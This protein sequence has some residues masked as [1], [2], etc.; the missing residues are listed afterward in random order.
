MPD[1]LLYPVTETPTAAP[2]A[3]PYHQPLALDVLREAIGRFDSCTTA[4]ETLRELQS[5]SRLLIPQARCGVMLRQRDG[6][7]ELACERAD[8]TEPAAKA[9]ST[10]AEQGIESGWVGLAIKQG[11]YRT[12]R[13]GEVWLFIKLASP[14]FVHGVAFWIASSIPESLHQALGALADLAALRLDRL[15][16]PGASVLAP[17]PN[18]DEQR[19]AANGFPAAAAD[20]LTGLAPRAQFLE[21]L[22][23]AFQGDFIGHSVGV[24]L[25]DIDG[26]HRVN[27]ELGCVVGDQ[28]LRSLAHRLE[29]TLRSPYVL[30]ALGSVSSDLCL[31]RTGADEL[32]VAIGHLR[33]PDRLLQAAAELQQHLA[34]GFYQG[35]HRLYLSVS[36]GLAAARPSGEE[37][38]A[39]TLLRRADAALKRAKSLGRNRAILYDPAWGESV[40]PHL[41]TES[42]LHEALQRS[43]FRLHFQPLFRIADMQLAGAEVLLRLSTS[44]GTPVPPSSFIPVAESTGQI[45]EISAWVL[46][47]LCQQIRAWDHQGPSSLPFALNLSAIELSQ[48][49]LAQRLHKILSQEG[50]APSR[51]HLEVTETAIA[52]NEAQAR[53][54]ISALRT[55]GFEVWL[56]DFGTGYS[57]LKLVKDLPFSGIKIDREFVMD[58]TAQTSTAVIAES[59]IAMASNLDFQVVAE[60]IEEPEQ[61]EFLRARH[62]EI[63]QGFHLGRPVCASDFERLYLSKTQP[64]PRPEQDPT[65][66]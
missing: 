42:L 28:V 59:I 50:I 7:L 40:S 60:G 63:G 47:R 55:A 9:L 52:R 56:D 13:Q 18:Q 62:C 26:F 29:T 32:G 23:Q 37:V 20:P 48:E 44:D 22:K 49:D 34:E 4:P 5:T 2:T 17:Q 30:Q 11:L 51:V 33:D 10:D 38:G 21:A 46:R 54:N 45:A 12:D 3:T 15:A 19:F 1:P 39:E 36:I 24:M 16:E 64:Q 43:L 53:D 58:L 61:L 35:A 8:P 6:C 31:A 66:T 14:R 57:S 27:R 25:L 41:R 65:P